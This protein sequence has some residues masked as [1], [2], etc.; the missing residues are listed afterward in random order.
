MKNSFLRTANLQ[1]KIVF[2]TG[3]TLAVI[4]LTLIAYSIS[5]AR[6]IAI[7]TAEKEALAFAE[8]QANA[9]R[10]DS[11]I[12]LDMARALAQAFSATKNPENPAMR[13]N[14]PQVNAMLRQVLEANPTFLG[15]YTLWEPNAF[16]G[17]DD[18]YRGREAHD[19]SGRFIPYWIRN[20]DGSISVIPLQ[21]YETP[22][23][24]DWYILPRGTK[25][26]TVIAPL[27]YPING[28]NTVMA[29]FVVPIVYRERFYGIAGVDMPIRYAQTLVDA[30]T[31]YGEQSQAFLIN[32][33][34][35]IISFRNQPEMVARSISEVIPDFA[36]S[37]QSRVAA[38]GAFISPSPDG[39]FL[40]VFAPARLGKTGASW[41][42]GLIIP[43][44]EITAAANAA[45]IRQTVI[46]SLLAILGLAGLWLL[47]RRIAR[48]VRELTE[49]A[50]QI[51]AGDLSVVAQVSTGDEIGVLASAFNAMTARLRE[52]VG[53]LEERVA[54]RTEQ[55]G[56]RN[57]ELALA[58]EVGQKVSQAI[59]L[60][61]MLRSAAE[62]IHEFFDLY[63]VQIYLVNPEKTE[64]VLR[65]GTGVAGKQLLAQ[66]HHLPLNE[67]S[68]NGRAAVT[69]RSIVIAD[70]AANPTFR[71]NPLLPETRSEIAIP[72]LI[73]DTLIGTLD[74]QSSTPG[75]LN[76]EALLAFEP[77]ARQIA[78]AIQNAR[79][80][81]E[82]EQSRREAEALARRM[83]RASWQEY[84]DAIHMPEEI[85]FAFDG[86]KVVP[87]QEAEQKETGET[88]SVP[89]VIGGETLG[90][91]SMEIRENAP[92]ARVEELLS[93]VARQTA[94]HIENLRLLESAERYRMEAEQASRRVTR[95]GWQEMLNARRG[96]LRFL[97]D[98]KEVKPLEETAPLEKAAL[99]APLKIREENVG[100]L[101][102][103]D[104]DPQ[105]SEAVEL[106]NAVAERLAGHIE[107]LRLAQQ[108]F[109]QAQREQILSQITSAVRG[110][111]DPESIL[112]T[113]VRE[114]GS[115]F[116]AK[117][118][119]RI[120]IREEEKPAS[121]NQS[122]QG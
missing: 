45:A 102:A 35:V 65:I 114:L 66:R 79:L 112:R 69:K 122:P 11:E 107:N 88:V 97:Y 115:L 5:T 91:L 101:A 67:N 39:K 7:Q 85:G 20:D 83:A 76:E 73:G 89:L 53:S 19:E 36:D 95:E 16:D 71:P 27:I 103:L 82:A 6:Q 57:R 2:W 70:T 63:Y 40:R 59:E 38:G 28:V 12:P 23:V 110:S 80:L 49:T 18:F 99:T 8:R 100:L 62:I 106:V 78:I 37:L 58:A 56:R 120:K 72:L 33:D 68:I 119:I 41:S 74:A 48:P 54:E 29:S 75:R 24:G 31:P 4:S 86:A 60:D 93:A 117:T 51:A 111:N 87:L 22:G 116:G 90:S 108:T 118:M 47:G 13:L 94:E 9:V 50:N 104:I 105:D 77:M 32:A 17:L 98:L 84:L 15:T 34:G 109:E 81:A 96:K 92:V 44:S 25:K 121:L 64:L 14:R 55:I 43:F 3:L 26:E 42:F 46:G 1:T 52:L 113:A 21:D 30:E 61:E 10:A